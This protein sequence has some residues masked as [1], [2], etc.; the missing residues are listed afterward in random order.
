M[1]NDDGVELEM[2][3]GT[4]KATIESV[5]LY[6]G[7]KKLETSFSMWSDS[8]ISYSFTGKFA[9]KMTAKFKVRTGLSTETISIKLNDQPLP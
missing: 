6:N 3:P 7:N 1:K 9:E 5:E 8:Q 4:V 2:R